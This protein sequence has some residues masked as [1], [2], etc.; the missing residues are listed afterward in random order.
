MRTVL[1][2]DRVRELSKIVAPCDAVTTAV[3]A[4]ECWREQ[5]EKP[6]NLF[7]PVHADS[8]VPERLHLVPPD[9]D[10][11]AMDMLD[12]IRWGAAKDQPRIGTA[13]LVVLDASAGM[14]DRY[15]D[16][17]QLATQFI[18]TMQHQDELDLVI[19]DDRQVVTDSRWR[20][21]AE[22][23]YLAHC[24]DS[25]KATLP[26]HTGERSLND[27]L[28]EV[29]HDAMLALAA[30]KATAP[31]HQAMVVI[32]TGRT[33]DSVGAPLNASPLA[34]DLP[35]PTVS[36]WLPTSDMDPRDSPEARFMMGLANPDVG[37]FFDVVVDGHD[38]KA[39]AFGIINV[40]RARFDNMWVVRW[41]G[42]AR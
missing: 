40:I 24:L 2:I 3:D 31:L 39:A 9:A 34:E 22:R 7:T 33:K 17:R 16:A 18:V 30:S 11:P 35:L 5:I 6:G 12:K 25:Q 15:E 21:F 32:S 13:W 14:G 36:L 19:I 10:S 20:N 1:S 38:A 41:Y 28:K 29:A 42:H 23:N 8:L 37:G 26:P 27:Q 4:A